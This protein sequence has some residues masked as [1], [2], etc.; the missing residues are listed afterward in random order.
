MQYAQVS[1]MDCVV[2]SGMP[3]TEQILALFSCACLRLAA[4]QKGLQVPT[5]SAVSALT[6]LP[7]VA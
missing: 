2:M 6:K 7:G 1:L 3:M 5:G 4:R